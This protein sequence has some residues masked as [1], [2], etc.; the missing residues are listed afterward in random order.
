MTNEEFARLPEL[1]SRAQV[2]RA[3]IPENSVDTIRVAL[4]SPDQ[5]VPYGKIGAVQL[6]GRK[7]KSAKAAKW[8][9][10]KADVAKMRG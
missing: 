8:K 1:L 7:C 6:P 3:G 10:R 5:R 2:V 9:Y 4:T